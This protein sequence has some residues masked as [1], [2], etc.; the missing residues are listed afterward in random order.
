[1]G[2]YTNAWFYK[3]TDPNHHDCANDGTCGQSIQNCEI[4]NTDIS[5]FDSIAFL[6][7]VRTGHRKAE[8]TAR[9]K[10]SNRGM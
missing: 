9:R 3:K 1:M 7:I 10:D 4:G 2:K 6:I 8:S 5:F